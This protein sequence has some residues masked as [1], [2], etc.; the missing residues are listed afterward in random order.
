MR[1]CMVFLT[2]LRSAPL[3]TEFQLMV[4]FGLQG[5]DVQGAASDIKSKVDQALPNVGNPL[6]DNPLKGGLPGSNTDFGIGGKPI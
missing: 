2:W 5:P 6:K 4:W 3:V 1:V